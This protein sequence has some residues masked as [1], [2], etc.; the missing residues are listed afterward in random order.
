MKKLFA[1]VIPLLVITSSVF[2]GPDV[3][4]AADGVCQCFEAPHEQMRRMME[5]SSKA[6]ESG[7]TSELEA[8]QEKINGVMEEFSHCFAALSKNFPEV[9]ASIEVQ[10]EVMDIAMQQCP[11]PRAEMLKK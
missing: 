10:K 5:L 8:A 7:D 9:E 3:N 2:A 11:D 6:E 1:T 4:K